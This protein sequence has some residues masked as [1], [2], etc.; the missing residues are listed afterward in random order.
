MKRWLYI[1]LRVFDMLVSVFSRA[2]NAFA[3]G[4]ST[5]QTTSARMHIEKWPWGEWL[6]DTL[7]LPY[8]RL[9]YG[10]DDHCKRAWEQ[11]VY[12][13]EKTLQRAGK[14]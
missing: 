5:H 10:R 8:E 7:F 6:V 14:H 3:L 4:G 12:H 11:E 13:A 2:F 1:A 9:V